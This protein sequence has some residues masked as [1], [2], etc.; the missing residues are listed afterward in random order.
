KDMFSNKQQHVTINERDLN[1]AKDELRNRVQ[2]VLGGMQQ[3][4]I[5]GLPLDTEELI[6][7]YYDTYNPDTATRQPLK[8]FSDLSAPVVEK[9]EGMA[10]QPNLEK[11][12][13]Q[14]LHH[15]RDQIPDTRYQTFGI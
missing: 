5:Q 14:G 9:G 8:N 11:E 12:L 2:A 3:C 7:L 1:K 15:C 13:P 10:Y 6:E 4:G